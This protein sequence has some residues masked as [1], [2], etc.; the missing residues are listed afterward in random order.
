MVVKE[1]VVKRSGCKSEV[2]LS[3][4][5][6]ARVHCFVPDVSRYPVLPRI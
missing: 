3:H 6:E 2:V 5:R 1:V 4:M